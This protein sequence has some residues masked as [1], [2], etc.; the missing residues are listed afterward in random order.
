[1]ADIKQI[2]RTIN[3]VHGKNAI[4]VGTSIK[5]QMSFKIPTGSISLNLKLGG[6]I[7]SGRLVTLAGS[8]ST[9]KSL[10]AYKTIANVQKMR[11]KKI[12][13]DGEEIEVIAED[14]DIPLSAALIQ[15]EQGSYTKEWGE[16]N[17]IDNDSLLFCQPEGMEQALDI[18]VALQRAGVELIV[19]DSYA[20]LMPTKALMTDFDDTYQMGIKPKMLGDYHNK[21][22]A[23]NNT[24]EREGRLPTTVLAINQ[25]REKIGV[26]YGSPEYVPGGRSSGFT[27]AVDIRLRTGDVISVGTGDNKRIVGRTIKYKI[28]KNKCGIP[29]TTGEY[30]LYFDD[31]E[32]IAA[33]SIDN[34][35]EL[36]MLAIYCGVIERR[37]AFYYFKEE[38]VAQ[39]LANLI[40][41]VRENKE[42]F[43]EIEGAV[44]ELNANIC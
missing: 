30:D 24:A 5:E 13:V 17:G 11:K 42:M 38:Q 29:F 6:G 31:N 1:M 9:G 4:R 27:N 7:P 12:M 16:L 44:K 2:V 39:G 37:G 43:S 14:G 36:I 15:T 22:Q 40:S 33:G 10:M 18:A 21:F 23:I 28:E 26:M 34:A 8:Y 20:T 3:K 35:K 25:I 32:D 41:S 19:I